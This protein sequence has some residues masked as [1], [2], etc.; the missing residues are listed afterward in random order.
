MH[1]LN[2]EDKEK[3]IENYVE[4]DT[5]VARKQV[6]DAEAPIKQEQ[7]EIRNAENVGVTTSEP[8]NMFEEIMNAIGDGLINLASCNNEADGDVENHGGTEVRNLS[9]DDEP[10]WVVGTIPK[11]VHQPIERF[12]Q[13]EMTH[14]NLTQLGWA[15]MANNFCE[16]DK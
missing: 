10:S 3:W 12:R 2:N 9:E 6:E 15:D 7:E 1:V 8:K 4:T 16:R 11:M 13:E 5:A 14:D